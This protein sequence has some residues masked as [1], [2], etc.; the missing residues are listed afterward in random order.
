MAKIYYRKT[1]P[2]I[3]IQRKVA[4]R[5]VRERTEWRVGDRAGERK[6]L[7]LCA[8]L[9]LEELGAGTRELSGDFANWVEPWLVEKYGSSTTTTLSVYQRQ[10]RHLSKWMEAKGHRHPLDITRA[11]LSDYRA[12]RDPDAQARNLG[13]RI[14]TVIGEI[15]TL[16]VILKEAKA[17]GHCREIVTDKL[18][19]KSEARREYEPWTDEEFAKAL[20]ASEK[21]KGDREWIRVALI[22][23]AYQA[24]RGRQVQVPLSAIDFEAGM[25]YWPKEVMT[26]KRADWVQPL[27]PRA[28]VLLKPIVAARR[29]AG[30]ATLADVA[31]LNSIK[32]RRWLDGLDIHKVHHGL[33]ATWITKAALAGVP[34]AVAMAF[35]HHSGPAVHRLYQRVR[36][37]QSAEFLQKISFGW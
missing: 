14:N 24:A 33:R 21:L 19:W 22:L 32:M 2:M 35:V 25:I 31:L 15:R 9:S 27:D 11:S 26:G 8:R 13:A 34:Q 1:S 10:W 30:K 36:P 29:K 12:W 20:S 16:G 37:S 5:W 18:G 6:A 23:G 7:S 28:A 3:W 17:R 4:G